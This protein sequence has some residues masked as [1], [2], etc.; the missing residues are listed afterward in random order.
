MDPVDGPILASMLGNVCVP[1]WFTVS[2]LLFCKWKDSRLKQEFRLFHIVQIQPLEG[3]RTHIST[4]VYVQHHPRLSEA[5]TTLSQR[6]KLTQGLEV[7]QLYQ[8]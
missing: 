6:L 2:V 5:S 4:C 8:A 1:T 3:F 7:G